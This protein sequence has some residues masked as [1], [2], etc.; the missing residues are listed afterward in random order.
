MTIDEV[1]AILV[2]AEGEGLLKTK[3]SYIDKST[4]TTLYYIPFTKVEV[5]PDGK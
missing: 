3:R 2:S 5:K 1:R 4:P